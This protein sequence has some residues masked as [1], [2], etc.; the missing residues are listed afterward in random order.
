M[1][2]VKIRPKI[3]KAPPEGEENSISKDIF[4]ML[5]PGVLNFLHRRYGHKKHV[6]EFTLALGA[7]AL[8]KGY[9]YGRL[10]VQ[11]H[12]SK[13]EYR[14]LIDSREEERVVEFIYDFI[15]S[16]FEVFINSD[17]TDPVFEVKPVYSH[18]QP[19]TRGITIVDSA[20]RGVGQGRKNFRPNLSLNPKEKGSKPIKY[21]RGFVDKLLNRPKKYHPA[22]DSGM[23]SEFFRLYFHSPESELV[24][25]YQGILITLTRK[26]KE[27]SNSSSS[28]NSSNFFGFYLELYV[29]IR[30]KDKLIQFMDLVVSKYTEREKTS[31]S[32]YFLVPDMY[33]LS[34]DVG[35]S[36]KKRNW[37]T[38]F[39]PEQMIVE[40]K[41]DI[42]H[43][44]RSIDKYE[45]LGISYK[46]NYLFSG[47]QGTGKTSLA[48]VIASQLKMNIYKLSLMSFEKAGMLE[49]LANNIKP[50]T[51]ILIEEVDKLYDNKKTRDES[52]KIPYEE[53][54]SFL[55]GANTPEGC[56]VVMTTNYPEKLDSTFI[57]KG[58]IDREFKFTY[59][60]LEPALRMF[61]FYYDIMYTPELGKEFSKVFKPGVFSASM[62]QHIFLKRELSP[63]QALIDIKEWN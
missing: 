20:E 39:L 26:N 54:L 25:N 28:Q 1:S 52:N 29:D 30:N 47:L 38:L 9:D 23:S 2:E 49:T 42:N 22:K 36:I 45:R 18:H 55:D 37:D 34:L 15:L 44:L 19:K 43:Y 63:E 7:F 21:E 35:R 59:I 41:T 10:V 61:M 12:T 11:R 50:N 6:N 58:R 3:P 56:I 4:N 48:I 8:T 31:D 32:I 53:F 60:E 13:K 46:R 40:I 5:L 17:G 27:G 57:R 16:N 33:D 62:L 14:M 24:F 51:L